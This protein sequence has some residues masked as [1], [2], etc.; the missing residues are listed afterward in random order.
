ME[1]IRISI[2][3]MESDETNAS[4]ISLHFYFV[5]KLKNV[6]LPINEIDLQYFGIAKNR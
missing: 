2:E 5:E 3:L 1:V 4:H 6:I